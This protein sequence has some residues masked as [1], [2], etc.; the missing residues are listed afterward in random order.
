VEEAAAILGVETKVI[1]VVESRDD[2][3]RAVA[4]AVEWKA[5]AVFR[6]LAQT[7][8]VWSRLQ[9]E[10]LLRHRLPAMLANRGDVEN[11]GL[12]CY[13]A[14]LSEHWSQVA[15]YVDRIL[16]GA[17][18]GDLPVAM[19]TKFEFVLNLKTAR[20]L[21]LTIPPGVL[22]IVDEVIE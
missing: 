3:E 22:A 14:D 19:P 10:L 1:P 16:K 4:A 17:A 6:I 8:G 11:G 5:D 20:A 7:G 9:A 13:F 12:M 2:V 18:A 21:G 15:A